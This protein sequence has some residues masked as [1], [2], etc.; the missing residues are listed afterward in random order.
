MH[1]T[2]GRQRISLDGEWEF[3]CDPTATLT[4]E[5]LCPDRT[6]VVPGAWQQVAALRRYSGVGWYQRTVVL[7]PRA[8]GMA[9]TTAMLHLGAVDHQC[10]VWVNGAPA[11]AHVGGY[12]PVILPVGHLL[13]SGQNVITVRVEDWAMDAVVLAR[14]P[15]EASP[16]PAADLLHG[17]QGWYAEVSGLWGQTWLELTAPTH[18][19]RLQV[20]PDLAGGR[21]HLRVALRGAGLDPTTEIEITIAPQGGKPVARARVPLTAME[22]TVTLAIPDARLWSPAHPAL[23]EAT[24][25]LYAAGAVADELCARFGMR[26]IAARDGRLW[27][28]G[29]PLYLR[30]ALDQDFYPETIYTPPSEAY[31]RAQFERA[32]ELGLNCL[33]LHIKP[34]DPRY[35]DLCDEMGLLVWAEL[36]SWRAIWPKERLDGRTSVP[37]PLQEMVERT[38]AEMV[39]RDWNHP[40]IIIWTL[41]NEDWGTQLVFSASDRG[42]LRDFFVRAKALDPTRL[43]VDNSPCPASH[44][45]NFHLQSDLDD[46][47]VYA[48][49]PERYQN[50]ARWL[51]D[52]SLRPAWSYSLHGDAVRHGD[53][54]LLVS[55][56]GTWGLPTMAALARHWPGGEAPWWWETG[57]WWGSLGGEMSYPA[58]APARFAAAGLDAIWPDYDAFA[59]A[60]QQHQARA[61]KAQIELIRRHAPI[62]G[63]IIT[64]FTDQYWEANGLLD[65]YRQPKAF[66]DQFARWNGPD[67]LLPRWQRASHWGG[68]T[69][70]VGL[71][72]SHW[73][74]LA[75]EGCHLQWEIAALGLSGEWAVAGRERGTTEAIGEIA[76]P[77]PDAGP[78]R[79]LRLHCRLLG[80]D[81][82]AIAETDHD[83][84]HLPTT[85]AR[86]RAA[87][88]LW[89]AGGGSTA[90]D[91]DVAPG[92]PTTLTTLAL[93]HDPSLPGV[94][95][96]HLPGTLATTLQ[97]LGY[98]HATT[99][100]A[101]DLIVASR[102]T[103]SLLAAVRAGAALLFLPEEGSPLLPVVGRGPLRDGDWISA[104]HWLRPDLPLSIPIE[105][106]L[107]FAFGPV[108]PA[109]VILGHG[110]RMGGD[111]L[112]GLV[113][114]WAHLPTAT[115][116]QFRYGLG[117]VVMSTWQLAEQAGRDPV[118]TALLHDLI[119]Y[120]ASAACQPG[121][122]LPRPSSR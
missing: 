44:G 49:M 93:A 80:A 42:W 4:V 46:F 63:Y 73:S 45:P 109:R 86:P 92:G 14:W 36:P 60:T 7:G 78:A 19:A 43:V 122:E 23:Y 39:A 13:H 27:L 37:P 116:C 117:R 81:G 77:L 72:L 30:G 105:N 70:R 113:T 8:A 107:G 64:E 61:L 115:L 119:A 15:D 25:T 94:P 18:I 22:T 32:R 90:D 62:Q 106:P 53:E 58:G 56:F 102:L 103:A 87:L 1:E 71:V 48:A 11:G 75:R 33:R 12:T 76:V 85:L 35:L 95:G 79:A 83:F 112:G 74:G 29:E 21:A 97:Q 121:M 91:Q 17:K 34:A 24:A 108:L 6:L 120:T 31:L 5:T 65:F 101:A 84:L 111:V 67:A 104:F 88:R 98:D 9:P 52:F 55:E 50:L 41:V 68:E 38:F 99:R 47:H 40:S 96:T 118:A 66:H 114:G 26:E 51:H 89:A 59:S 20:T 2:R 3:Q 28:N 54:P 82:R 10:E 16:P 69:L 57:A 110:E 100:E